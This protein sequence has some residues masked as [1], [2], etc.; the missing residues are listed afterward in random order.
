M[1]KIETNLTQE[2]QR[3]YFGLL[4]QLKESLNNTSDKS[5]EKELKEK[6][7]YYR[8]MLV[9]EKLGMVFYMANKY[10]N[11]FVGV[12][13]LVEI[14]SIALIE[15]FDKSKSSYDYFYKIELYHCVR[16]SMLYYLKKSTLANECAYESMINTAEGLDVNEVVSLRLLEDYINSALKNKLDSR[17]ER[18]IRMRYGIQDKDCPKE[19]YD[20]EHT[21]YE[22]AKDVGISSARVKMILKRIFEI[23]K[24][25]ATRNDLNIYFGKSV[26]RKKIVNF[27]ARIS[28]LRDLFLENKLEVL[29]IIDNLSLKEQRIIYLVLSNIELEESEAVLNV[30]FKVRKLLGHFVYIHPDVYKAYYESVLIDGSYLTDLVKCTE[31]ELTELAL[32]FFGTDLDMI[33]LFECYGP[34]L[35]K[36]ARKSLDRDTYIKYYVKLNRYLQDKREKAS[37]KLIN[38]LA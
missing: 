21:V 3:N 20:Y 10:A 4:K 26:P 24:D 25:Y 7:V 13:E 2:Q 22:I 8:N 15:A 38:I 28:H 32:E 14:G 1:E 37:M 35:N 12:E 18:I 36:K 5:I 31:D 11:E 6:Y 27:E 30:C 17:E 23:L 29:Q 19:E 9:A 16:N 33:D 34:L